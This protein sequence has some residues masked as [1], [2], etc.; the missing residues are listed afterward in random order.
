V[1]PRGST[2][3]KH[4]C[5]P[6]IARYTITV[7]LG[8]QRIELPTSYISILEPLLHDAERSQ[9]AA[10]ARPPGLTVRAASGA[11]LFWL[12]PSV[13][14]FAGAAINEAIAHIVPRLT[15]SGMSVAYPVD[16]GNSLSPIPASEWARGRS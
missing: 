13:F 1:S 11:V 3:L 5:A 4:E 10:A 6:P 2:S 14:F 12:L 9:A 7:S 8:R 15:D 16:S